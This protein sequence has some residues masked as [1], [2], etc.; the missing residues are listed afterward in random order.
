MR[1]STPAAPC[2]AGRFDPRLRVVSQSGRFVSEQI[3]TILS[4]RR[5]Q[6]GRNSGASGLVRRAGGVKSGVAALHQNLPP[7]P[8]QAAHQT[9]SR[10][11][12]QVRP[13]AQGRSQTCD[14]GGVGC[15]RVVQ[16]GNARPPRTPSLPVRRMVGSPRRVPWMD[17]MPPAA[18]R[19]APGVAAAKTTGCGNSGTARPFSRPPNKMCQEALGLLR[20][21]QV[22]RGAAWLQVGAVVARAPGSA[23]RH[24]RY[25]PFI[26]P[27]HDSR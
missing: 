5:G 25:S 10:D 15:L 12:Q 14:R 19:F 16:S 27:W 22:A 21:P 9:G 23:A 26:T 20:Q 1:P 7:A 3:S 8:R 17:L 4:A 18:L 11:R 2:A 13:C 6:D 24:D